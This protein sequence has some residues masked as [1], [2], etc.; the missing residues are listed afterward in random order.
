MSTQLSQCP[1]CGDRWMIDLDFVHA[2]TA[3]IEQLTA[4]VIADIICE[5]CEESGYESHT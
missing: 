3:E 1:F 5:D 4:H 2:T